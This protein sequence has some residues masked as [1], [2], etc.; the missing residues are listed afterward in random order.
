MSPLSL[1]TH[2]NAPNSHHRMMGGPPLGQMTNVV[3]HDIEQR[4]IEYIKMF[5]TPK[6]PRRK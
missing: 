5:Q 3:P 1:V 4:M 2:G 6:E